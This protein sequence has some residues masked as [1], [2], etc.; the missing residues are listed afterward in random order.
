MLLVLF[1][2][3]AIAGADAAYAVRPLDHSAAAT[4]SRAAH[5][6]AQVR[7]LIAALG[8]TNVIVHLEVSRLLP[9]GLGGTTRFIAS[10][11][12]YRYLRMSISAALPPDA[13]AAILGHELQH[14]LE[15][16]RSGASDVKA[17]EQFLE[18]EGYRVNGR[19]FET[20]AALRVERA[21]REELRASETKPIVELHHQHLRAGGAKTAAQIAKR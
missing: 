17:L 21:V 16:A 19:Y 7:A 12:G 1:F 3:P 14:A 8:E 2:V 9:I 4:L 5:R 11:G 13:R 15:I 10:R 6:S 18:K 20:A